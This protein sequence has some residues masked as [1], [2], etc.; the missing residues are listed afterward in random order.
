MKS[1]LS[2][3]EQKKNLPGL[4]AADNLWGLSALVLVG[5]GLWRVFG[6]LEK[7]TAYY[8]QNHTFWLK[9][10]LLLIIILLEIKP[11]V[12]FIRW[13]IAVKCGQAL[14]AFESLTG[15]KLIN[16]IQ[17]I[18]AI[19]IPFAASFMARGT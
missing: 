8:M 5:T 13:R 10:T 7:G 3:A 9:M 17:F 18:V 4:F 2:G 19:L 16:N 11:M 12:T 14:P 15:L 1:L 6:G